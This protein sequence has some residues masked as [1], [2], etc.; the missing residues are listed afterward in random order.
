MLTKDNRKCISEQEEATMM[1]G[2]HMTIVFVKPFR[3][4]YENT[5]IQIY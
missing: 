3:S 1:E 2:Y 4:H 5:P